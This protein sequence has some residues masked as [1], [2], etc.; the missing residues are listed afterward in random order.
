M[1]L[2]AFFRENA[3]FLS[4]GGLLSF[5][6]CYGQTFFIAIFAAQ[7]MGAYGLSD[8][9]W[10]GLYTISTTASAVIMFWAGTLADHYRV[11]ALVWIVMP[12]LALVCLAMA[13]NKTIA[14]L[15]VIV[16][17]LRFLGQGM[18]NQLAVV[19]MARWFDARRGLALSISALG[20]SVGQAAFPVIVASLFLIMSWRSVWVLSAALLMLAFPL[21]LW[22][23]SAERTPQSHVEATNSSGMHGRHWTRAE[24][25]RSRLFW[26]L[27][28]ML[29]GPPA[30]GTALFFQQVHIAEVKG[31]PLVDYLALIPL[32]TAVSVVVTVISGQAIDR[33]GSARLAILYLVPFALAFLVLGLAETLA[34]AAFGMALFG[35]A[36]G[37]QATLPTAFWAEFFGTR[38][39]GAIKAVS[40]SIMV[41]GSAVGP[42]IS[43]ALID[44]GLTFPEQMIG[45]SV[46]FVAASILVWVAVREA[47]VHLPSAQVDIKG[48]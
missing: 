16:F 32:L 22:V 7:I 39:I 40:T 3:R 6:S 11:R 19:A 2:L 47:R 18:M 35:I 28:P 5:S 23:L 43:G 25:L 41:F 31:W 48:A 17:L 8:G 33:F 1:S 21:M 42:G 38:H 27:L 9:V 12:A 29:L 34:V 13:A 15:I 37:I 26:M 4:A 44:F 10:G 14:G 36:H 24:V 46:F 30:W 20:F 45:I